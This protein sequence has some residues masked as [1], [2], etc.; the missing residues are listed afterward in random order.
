MVARVLAPGSSGARA[1]RRSSA[2]TGADATSNP[3]LR[4]V[5]LDAMERDEAKDPTTTTPLLVG[6]KEVG[7][8]LGVS[9]RTVRALNSSGRIPQPIHLG[10]RT[11]W[12][13]DELRAW[14]AAG[15]PGRHR[16]EALRAARR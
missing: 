10:R 8:L 2:P 15:C 16:W 3:P 12:A 13:V 14:V 11:L 7:A 9:E 5:R 1:A 6:A 4:V